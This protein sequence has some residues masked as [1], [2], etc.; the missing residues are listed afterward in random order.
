MNTLGPDVVK[1]AVVLDLYAGT[2]AVGIEA[3]SRGAGRAVFVESSRPALD[4]LRRNLEFLG[5]DS[6]EGSVLAADVLAV[7]DGRV[8]T[9][10]APFD[11]VFCDP[12][13]EVFREPR[14][15]TRLAAALARFAASE[16][17]GPG[18]RWVVEHPAGKG[19][20]VL[21][22]GLELLESRSY[23]AAGVSYLTAQR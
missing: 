20:Q 15:E 4:A 8:A 13:Y 1:G 21:P 11:V 19:F 5:V 3:L 18:T 14:R 10:V 22:E 23:S 17:V 16:A 9:P 2:G 7:L 12:P 6:E